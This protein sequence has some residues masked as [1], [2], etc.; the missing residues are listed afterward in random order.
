MIFVQA[1]LCT[2]MGRVERRKWLGNKL[3]KLVSLEGLF[4]WGGDVG[5]TF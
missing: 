5:L 4:T 2:V 3:Y 1:G